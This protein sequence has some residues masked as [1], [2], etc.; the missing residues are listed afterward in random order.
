MTNRSR[1]FRAGL[2]LVLAAAA[3]ALMTTAATAQNN[4]DKFVVSGPAAKRVFAKNEISLD[5][6]K[7]ITAA[8]E[9]Y[10]SQRNFSSSIVVL[11]PAGDI[12]YAVRMDGLR[13]NSSDAAVYK[14]ETALYM[15]DSSGAVMNRVTSMEER[16][17]RAARQPV[18]FRPGGLL[19]IVDDQLI[20]A[21]GVA[22]G[23]ADEMCAYEAVTKIVGAQPPL[24]A[25]R[26]AAGAAAAPQG[27]PTQ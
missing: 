25:P 5:T 27:Q 14:A 2:I 15:R 23:R 13:P 19:I 11:G 4:I 16:L 1:F 18:W 9:E 7:K 26:P 10:S 12:V 21:I 22:G 3:F 6:A 24:P 8:C 17:M 20:G